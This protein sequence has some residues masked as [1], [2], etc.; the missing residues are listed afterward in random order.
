M[1]SATVAGVTS[2]VSLAAGSALG[3]W[4]ANRRLET[5]YQQLLAEEIEVTKE[6]Y[7]VLHKGPGFSTPEEAA[8]SLG[9]EV[10]V[11]EKVNV[12]TA[13]NA[14]T[15]YQGKLNMPMVEKTVNIFAH[16]NPNVDPSQVIS[17]EELAS[18]SEQIAYIISTAELGENEDGYDQV[19]Y[20]WYEGDKTLAGEQDEILDDI[21]NL[22]GQHNLQMFGHRSEDPNVV[23]VRNDTMRLD[24]QIVRSEGE[25]A[26]EV[27]GFQRE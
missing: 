23:N 2:A 14:L 7:A 4:F 9:V 24:I 25:Y 16:K 19:T 27:A 22:V 13:E 20:T 8:E 1:N 18:R 17:E 21:D 11:E 12:V 26:V 6:Y 10:A 5:K 3:Y 15:A